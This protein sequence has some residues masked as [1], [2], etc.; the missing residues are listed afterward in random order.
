MKSFV[1]CMVLIANFGLIFGQASN[2]HPEDK[3]S[4]TGGH[5]V[6]KDECAVEYAYTDDN[7]CPLQSSQGAICC[8]QIPDSWT[9]CQK[10][11]GECSDESMCGG[12]KKDKRGQCPEGKVC[13]VF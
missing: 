7:Y 12:P 9:D 8:T 13:C 4:R 2:F 11:G 1:I 5:C 6:H 3:C 10:R